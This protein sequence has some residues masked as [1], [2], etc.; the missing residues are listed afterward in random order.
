MN[1]PLKQHVTHVHNYIR[2]G[3]G[4]AGYLY[5]L[6]LGLSSVSN[7]PI[8]IV[9]M[10]DT[11]NRYFDGGSK[12]NFGR[13]AKIIPNHLIALS[14]L[15]RYVWQWQQPLD[16]DQSS[17]SRI[18]QSK[19]IVFHGAI[20]ARRYLSVIKKREGQK[21]YIMPHGPT[22]YASEMIEDRVLRYGKTPFWDKTRDKLTD[23]EL[24]TYQLADGI[25]APY[26]QSLDS[27]FTFDEAK[28]A[29]FQEIPLTEIP[30]GVSAMKPKRSRRDVL[31][32]F[33]IPADK[34]II[35][36]F[37]RYHTHK[38][39]DLFCKVAEL[40]LSRNDTRFVFVSAGAGTI[41][42]PNLP[43]F[44]DLGWQKEGLPDLINA[45]DLVVS[46]NNFTYFDLLI[47]EV[48]SLGK[49]VL[50]SA[51][52][53]NLCLNKNSMGIEL[54][55]SLTSSSICQS[56]EALCLPDVLSKMGDENRRV[57][58]QMYSL[59]EFTNRHLA[60]AQDCLSSNALTD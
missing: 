10:S 57:Y 1:T 45:V 52:G 18:E 9:T 15:K 35:G 56:L 42:A 20:L 3:G 33:G 17:I 50:A 49:P 53:G 2:P 23:L 31:S 48:M 54:L 32:S 41:E 8:Q 34:W 36:F 59:K 6:K 39:F 30:T 29:V 13:F 19:A 16:F 43:N 46:P 25:I 47:L 27:Y 58:E 28:R 4:P 11:E 14:T 24:E 12:K 26:K 55:T 40:C 5:N 51:V 37:G 22:D 21:I 38:G 60:F 44:F 7:N